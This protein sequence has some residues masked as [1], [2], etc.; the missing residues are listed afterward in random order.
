MSEISNENEGESEYKKEH[1]EEEEQNEDEEEDEENGEGDEE[2]DEE[3]LTLSTKEI[4]PVSLISQKKTE[5]FLPA[6]FIQRGSYLVCVKTKERL[7][8]AFRVGGNVLDIVYLDNKELYIVTS[9]FVNN[10][11][12]LENLETIDLNC[13]S[14]KPTKIHFKIGDEHYEF[15]VRKINSEEEQYMMHEEYKLVLLE[16]L[17]YLVFSKITPLELSRKLFLFHFSDGE[18]VVEPPYIEGIMEK[19]LSMKMGE[20]VQEIESEDYMENDIVSGFS[21]L[22]K[23]FYEMLTEYQQSPNFYLFYDMFYIIHKL[24]LLKQSKIIHPKTYYYQAIYFMLESAFLSQM[25]PLQSLINMAKWIEEF[26]Q[27]KTFKRTLVISLLEKI[28]TL[29]NVHLNELKPKS[30]MNVVD[31]IRL[32]ISVD[33]KGVPKKQHYINVALRVVKFILDK[34][35]TVLEH[36]SF[37]SSLQ[38]FYNKRQDFFQDENNIYSSCI[39]KNLRP[40]HSFHWTGEIP[41]EAFV[42]LDTEEKKHF[43][44]GDLNVSST[45]KVTLDYFKKL[46]NEHQGFATIE[47]QYYIPPKVYNYYVFDYYFLSY[48]FGQDWFSFLLKKDDTNMRKKANDLLNNTSKDIS[49]IFNL[50]CKHFDPNMNCSKVLQDKLIKL[51]TI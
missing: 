7:R 24:A 35:V 41:E 25:K 38:Y 30:N 33:L 16:E 13:S 22:E 9:I 17:D 31:L 4:E 29:L 47:D 28:Q 6:G 5:T 19:S 1:D 23:Q 2:D 21:N 49:K 27:K 20:E 39:L 14:I 51:I 3:V 43:I 44:T 26:K 40:P 46:L 15:N 11:Q 8:G 48:F 36:N 45:T 32:C 34:E 37:S 12:Q 50:V 10:E 18:L 42:N